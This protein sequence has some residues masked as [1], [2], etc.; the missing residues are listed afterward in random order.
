[1]EYR[2]PVEYG[3]ASQEPRIDLKPQRHCFHQEYQ[4]W[5]T[6]VDQLD[7]PGMFKA[8]IY[9]HSILPRILCWCMRRLSPQSS[10][11]KERSASPPRS[12][13][14]T[15]LYGTNNILQ[16]PISGLTEELRA[17]RT[18]VQKI[19]RPKSGNRRHPGS[20][21]QKMEYRHISLDSAVTTEAEGT[22]GVP[23]SRLQGIG[24]FSFRRKCEPAERWDGTTRSM[25]EMV[26]C[27]AAKD[28]IV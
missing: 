20:D 15:A 16:L 17:S 4:S 19:Q 23:Y 5:L 25:D 2:L 22:D 12:L 14:S 24:Y 21:G 1:M 18:Q 3:A 11:W 9:Q 26:K 13:S 28:H 7:L 27:T 6:K 10:L 8:W